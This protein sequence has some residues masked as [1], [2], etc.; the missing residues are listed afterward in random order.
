MD[1]FTLERWGPWVPW[2]VSC[3][4]IISG[5]EL[6]FFHPEWFSEKICG[7]DCVLVL[8]YMPFVVLAVSLVK[9][10]VNFPFKY[11]LRKE[12]STKIGF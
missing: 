1:K 5:A 7:S 3:S 11:H 12:L 4:V 10:P 6:P 8:K 2:V 9:I